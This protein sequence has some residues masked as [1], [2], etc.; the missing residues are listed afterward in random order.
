MPERFEV[1]YRLDPKKEDIRVFGMKGPAFAFAKRKAK[2]NFGLH[3]KVL[4]LRAIPSKEANGSDRKISGRHWRPAHRWNIH[5]DG[6]V[7]SVR[8]ASPASA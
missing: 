6:S 7:D 8:L 2:S 5:E 4:H 3:I 1:S